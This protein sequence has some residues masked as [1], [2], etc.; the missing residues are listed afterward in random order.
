MAQY[1]VTFLPEGKV[2][3]VSSEETLLEAAQRAGTY[4]SSLCGGDM[5]CGKCR[6]VVKE[7]QVFRVF[8][9]GESVSSQSGRLYPVRSQEVGRIEIVS[10]GAT[11]A[12]AKPVSGGSFAAGQPILLKD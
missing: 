7:G 10:V 11:D 2:A 3:T 1:T 9:Q 5:I 6:L 8:S 4:V 12:V